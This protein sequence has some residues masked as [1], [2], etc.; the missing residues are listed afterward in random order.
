MNHKEVIYNVLLSDNQSPWIVFISEHLF[1]DLHC[2]LSSVQLNSVKNSVFAPVRW[3]QFE[4][5]L[6][7]Y[8]QFQGDSI[9]NSISLNI[10]LCTAIL[11]H[12][13]FMSKVH[14]IK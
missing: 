13:Q 12:V 1:S 2:E 11:T 4:S 14:N 10:F 8:I 3:T 5:S 9:H 6:I 7:H